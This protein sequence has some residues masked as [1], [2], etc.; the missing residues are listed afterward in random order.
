MIGERSQVR[1]SATA[2][3]P[4]FKHGMSWIQEYE[5]VWTEPGQASEG[6]IIMTRTCQ[7][8]SSIFCQAGEKPW[9]L[10]SRLNKT[11]EL[12]NWAFLLTHFIISWVYLVLRSNFFYNHFSPFMLC[13]YLHAGDSFRYSEHHVTC[14]SAP[15]TSTT[16]FARACKFGAKIKINVFSK[17]Y[18]HAQGSMWI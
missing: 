8:I 18:V 5:M 1:S 15:K 12:M 10:F 2:R 3:E 14:G 9:C 7:S 13:L 17:Y 4:S 11:Y 6:C 16:K